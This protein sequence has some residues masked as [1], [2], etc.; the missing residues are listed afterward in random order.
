MS[1]LTLNAA[2]LVAGGA[3]PTSLT[4]AFVSLG[5][6]TGVKWSNTGHEALFV[7]V[8]TT[9][10]TL[11][12]DIPLIIQGEP[13]QG[14]SSGVLPASKIAIVGPYPSQFDDVTDMVEID[15]SSQTGISVALIRWPGVI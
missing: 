12:S 1:L 6:N 2:Q 13:V 9:P 3:S 8:G 15:F 10:T 4:D 5:A 11:T 14:Q 7:Q